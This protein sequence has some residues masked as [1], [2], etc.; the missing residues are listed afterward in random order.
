MLLEEHRLHALDP[1]LLLEV[2]EV[3]EGL[4]EDLQGLSL[5]PGNGRPHP[6][7]DPESVITDLLGDRSRGLLNGAARR[8][9]PYPQRATASRPRQRHP[10]SITR[11]PRLLIARIQLGP[12]R[13][14][15]PPDEALNAA[16]GLHATLVRLASKYPKSSNTDTL[17]GRASVHA[18]GSREPAAAAG[19]AASGRAIPARRA[20][21]PGR[22]RGPPVRSC[23]T[24]CGSRGGSRP[25]C[26]WGRAGWSIPHSKQKA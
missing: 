6:N 22:R 3:L 24:S 1:A 21:V 26:R 18:V 13:G 10:C 17:S 20:R 5:T 19:G 7:N 23:G 15:R 25:R 11:R 16:R 12:S 2:R 4:A 8:A 14:C 9:Q